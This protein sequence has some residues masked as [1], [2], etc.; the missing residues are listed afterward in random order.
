[1]IDVSPLYKY[2][3]SG[4]GRRAAGRPRHHPRRDAARAGPV[5]YTPW[6]DEAGKVI[7]DGTLARLDD[8]SLSAGRRPTRSSAGCA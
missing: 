4:P 1:M 3:V 6:C 2:R 8:G 5:I 7:D